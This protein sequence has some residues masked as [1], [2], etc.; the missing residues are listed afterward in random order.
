MLQQQELDLP[1]GVQSPTSDWMVKSGNSVDWPMSAPPSDT[2]SNVE[3]TKAGTSDRVFIL[4][5]VGH[6]GVEHG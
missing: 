2:W 3:W 6:I 4:G 1:R 5:N